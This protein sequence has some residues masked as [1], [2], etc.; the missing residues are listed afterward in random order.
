MDKHLLVTLSTD[1]SALCGVR[2][3]ADFFSAPEHLRLTFFY[4]DSDP[5]S[6]VAE[7]GGHLLQ[8]LS[9]D[10]DSSQSPVSGALE[11]ARQLLCGKG[12]GAGHMEAKIVFKRY[13]KIMDIILESEKG[14]YDALVLGRRGLTRLEEAFGSSVSRGVLE[15]HV[16]APLW[17]CR[18]V[19][20]GRKNVL[21]CVDGSTS[22]L[23]MAD[24]VGFMLEHE[25]RH[26]V[27]MLSIVPKNGDEGRRQAEKAL[28]GSM[29][30]LL[31]NNLSE[32]RISARIVESRKISETILEEAD[33][34]RYAVVA[35]GRTGVGQGRFPRLF[36]GSA[37]DTIYQQLEGAALWVCR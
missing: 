14:L 31:D 28:E 30:A 9:C 5:K 18:N 24:H 8:E 12:F 20:E 2:F 10:I 3:V 25:P 19:E 7:A 1:P 26:D 27:T 21:L 37:S 35:M 16:G 29:A 15:K 4:T 32:E 6:A 11:K 22:S 17:I 36:M 13:S 33:A 23:A 34:G